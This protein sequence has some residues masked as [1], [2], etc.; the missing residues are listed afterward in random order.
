MI[1]EENK[2]I[3]ASP[4][5]GSAVLADLK[6]PIPENGQAA[7]SV[8]L[9]VPGLKQPMAVSYQEFNRSFLGDPPFAPD[10]FVMKEILE[11]HNRNL[12]LFLN[13]KNDKEC[14]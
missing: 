6:F 13:C 11:G 12:A 7:I 2:P 9:Y 5:R 8:V 14:T 1:N 4:E 3:E 10:H